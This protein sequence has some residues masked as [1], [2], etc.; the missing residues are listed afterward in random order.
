MDALD[1]LLSQRPSTD[2]FAKALALLEALPTPER[3]QA[4]D[5][6]R[7]ALES[8]PDATREAPAAAWQDIQQGMAPPFWWPLVRHLQLAEGDSLEVGPALAPLTSVSSSQVSVDV[9]PLREAHQLRALDL[10]GNEALESLDFLQTTPRLERLVLSGLE[11]LPDLAPLRALPA[12]HSLTLTFNPTLDDIAPLA[13]LKV[14]RWLEL[15]GNERL[16]DFGPLATLTE[17]ERLV[18]DD[19][20][21]LRDLAFVEALP[22]LRRLSARRLPLLEELRP[23]ANSRLQELSLGGARLSDGTPLGSITS[24]TRLVLMEV[25]RLA[26][27]SFLQSLAA[28]RTLHLSELSI[29]L[30]RLKA[31]A[32]EELF[33]SH[34]AQVLDLKAL[35]ALPALKVLTLE[36]LPVKDLTPLAG[37]PQLERLALTRC[38]HVRDLSPLAR[39]PL[40]QLALIEPAPALDTS[41]LPPGCEVIR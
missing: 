6:A 40:R 26:D 14:L 7:T 33:I 41:P 32:L 10:T 35:E 5:R 16:E 34:C 22:K 9:S 23:L 36:D 11:L 39:L 13:S 20:G 12:L 37:L 8:W 29:A 17:L 4:V 15:S 1:T 3:E 28:L 25:P 31:P 19:C 21:G 30:P 24:L 27:L 2:R 38:P 18:V